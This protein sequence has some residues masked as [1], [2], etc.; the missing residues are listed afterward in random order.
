MLVILS[1]FFA[2]LFDNVARFCVEAQLTVD[3]YNA[4]CPNVDAI[5]RHTIETLTNQ[6]NVVPPSTLRLLVH[7]CFVEGCDGSILISSTSNNTAER[8]AEDNVSFPQIAFDAIIQVKKAVEAACPGVVSCADIL[9]MVAR[10]AVNL[11]GGPSWDVAKGRKDGL[12]SQASRVGGR[13]PG[14]NFN[15]TQLIENFAEVNLTAEDMVIL[16][17]GHTIGF[18]HCLQ[19]TDRLYNFT[20]RINST[21]PSMN[22]TFTETLKEACP[23]FATNQ[24]KVQAFDITTAFSFDNAYYQNL[25]S[26]KGLLF[27]DQVLFSDNR[28]R[29]LVEKLANSKE[30]FFARFVPAMIK[31]SS[32]GIK[33]KTD[34]EIRQDCTR[35]NS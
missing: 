14:S 2:L 3:F 32:I 6:S 30:A 24:A 15:V 17:G 10:D 21:D 29:T 27:S 5:V 12:I 18:S 28:T 4:T 22:A 31:M 25:Q 23:Q 35:F 13:L 26:G 19:F 7:D 11:T 8:D 20:G 1:L 9:A 16:S 34:G 33:S